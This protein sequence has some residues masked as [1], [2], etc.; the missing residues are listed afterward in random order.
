VRDNTHH[1]VYTHPGFAEQ[2]IALAHKLKPGKATPPQEGISLRA[3]SATNPKLLL[4]V[5]A[6]TGELSSQ[7]IH[8]TPAAPQAVAARPAKRRFRGNE[9]QPITLQQKLPLPKVPRKQSLKPESAA[10]PPPVTNPEARI[11][12]HFHSAWWQLPAAMP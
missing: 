10:V 12:Q 3:S 8:V 4:H 1:S 7:I 6:P 2:T 9:N 5:P 11:T